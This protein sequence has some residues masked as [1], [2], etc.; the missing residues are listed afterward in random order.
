MILAWLEHRHLIVKQVPPLKNLRH[1]HLFY[2]RRDC[3][4]NYILGIYYRV[5]CVKIFYDLL[6]ISISIMNP[7]TWV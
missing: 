4:T 1:V 5:K 6:F 2:S 7:V 3:I